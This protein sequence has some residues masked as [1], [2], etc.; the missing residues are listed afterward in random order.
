MKFISHIAF[1]FIL[2]STCTLAKNNSD[3]FFDFSY[4]ESND[5]I[6]LY[7]DKI[8][9][10][11]MYIGSL[12]SGVGSNDIQLDRGQL[13][14][15]KIVKFIKRGNKLLLIE[16]NQKYRA[17]SKNNSEKKSV[18]QAF[19][20]SV[21]FGFEILETD[22]GVYKID[23]T[24]FLM[25]DRHGVSNRLKETNQGDYIIDLSKSAIEINNTKAFPEN[26]EFEALLTFTGEAEGD[27]IRS[28]SPDPNF[29]S[30]IQ[31]HSFIKLPDSKYKPRAFDPRSGAIH[32][33]F[34]D[35]SVP[36]DE[37]I[38][39]KYI[40]RHRLEKKNPKSKISEAIE[41]IVYYLD[42]GTPEPIKSALLDGARWWNEAFESI[43]FK[44]AFQVKLL[45]DDADPMD[46]RYNVIQWVHR[47][48]RGWSYGASIV[49]PRTGEIIKGHV[50]LGSLRIRQDFLI[51]Q[52]LLKNPYKNQDISDEMLEMSLA[53]IRQLSA[54]EIGHTLGFAHNFT[55]ST[56]DRSSVMDYPH[57]LITLKNNEISLDNAYAKGIGEWDKVTVAYSYSEFL[58][59]QNE[60]DELNKILKNSYLKGYRFITDYDARAKGGAHATAHL[61]DNNKN[62]IYGLKNII[63]IRE[64]AINNF[65]IYNVK[66]GSTYSQLEDAFVPLYFMHR[67]QTEAVVKLIGGLNYNYAT[68]GDEQLVVEPV[69]MLV[70]EEALNILFET[71]K[72]D[73]LAIP[74][75]KLNLFPPRAYGFPRT[76]ESF[77]SK[78]GVAFD[79]ASAAL[80]SS[81]FT[82][83]LLLHPERLNRILMQNSLYNNSFGKKRGSLIYKLFGE[84]IGI[85]EIEYEQDKEMAYI[86]FITHMIKVNV[87]K[88]LLN[89]S[90]DERYFPQ[91][92]YWAL[93]AIK[94]MDLHKRNTWAEEDVIFDK[95]INDFNKN[96]EK[97]KVIESPTIPDG[98]P[99][100]S[101]QCTHMN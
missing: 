99:I 21:I 57:P 27:W 73:F 72:P 89:I 91:I 96:P 8:D 90:I 64:K 11:F 35:Y 68:I 51:A 26:I 93:D 78:L 53:R 101:Y 71:L 65:S 56:E 13:G 37:N 9:Y 82:L 16:P 70:Q 36:V 66:N 28:V 49:D 83:S 5:K 63:E 45:P 100:G 25:Y 1:I 7:V 85:G 12:S 61:W 40:I 77:K 18:E 52:S 79:P 24:P 41:P 76:R 34:M 31:H 29:V 80:T 22:M 38:N 42:P 81:E 86:N 88:Q 48:T 46:C 23:L 50:S 17:S 3:K 95:M 20:K 67:Y 6:F 30:V 10:E 2:F 62:V 97:F 44:D 84:L 87:L 75:D 69:D 94:N 60:K 19:A 58:D 98:S 39:K 15:E 54:H 74:K 43:G 4:D 59:D 92:R 14:S 33:S 47:S 55:S 32:I